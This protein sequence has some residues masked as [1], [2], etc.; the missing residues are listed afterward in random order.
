MIR[1]VVCLTVA[2]VVSDIG[3]APAMLVAATACNHI[4]VLPG[5]QTWKLLKKS[6]HC[7]MY[8]SSMLLPQAGMP[9]A[10]IPCLM[11]QNVLAGLS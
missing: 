3:L 2:M 5:I 4:A 9:V 8:W 6:Y 1:T 7:Q 10:L 11:V